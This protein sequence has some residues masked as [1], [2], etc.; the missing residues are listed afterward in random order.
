MDS[1]GKVLLADDMPL[2]LTVARKSLAA[3]GYTD[4]VEAKD[5]QEAWDL[6]SAA[7]ESFTLIVSDWMMPNLTGLELLKKVRADE[8]FAKIP[9]VLV[10]MENEKAAVVEAVKAGV[11]QFIVKPYTPET[12]AEKLETMFAKLAAAGPT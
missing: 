12:F 2:M 4:V 7:R 1:N 8:R 6:L 5:G 3:M 9:F 11:T 10:T